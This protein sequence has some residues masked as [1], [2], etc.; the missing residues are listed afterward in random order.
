MLRTCLNA[1]LAA[2]VAFAAAPADAQAP[3]LTVKV[4][5]PGRADQYNFEIAF[6]RGYFAE[7]GLEV[8][9]VAANSAQEYVSAI[10]SNQIQVASG[11]PN[12]GLFN[13]LDR[14]IDI[15]MVADWAHLGD[16]QGKDSVAIVVRA[17]LFDSGA[18]KTIADLK[19]R[20]IA[21][22]P[23]K[24]MYPDVLDQ[25]MFELAK[26]A[27]ADVTVEYLA[28]ADALAAMSGKKIDAAFMVEPLITQAD[29][30]NIARVLVRAGA[31]DPGAELALLMYSAEF[32]KNKDAATKFMV[33][34]LKGARDYYDAFYMNKDRD[35]VIK[36]L[37]EYLPVKDPKLW[38]AATPGHTDLNGAIN[39]ADLKRQAAFFREQGTLS[40]AV[41]DLDKYVTAEFAD[42]AVKIIGRR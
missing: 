39:V 11:S 26:L 19:G 24:A 13:A 7:Q 36:L 20:T 29:S 15:R 9:T 2:F 32:A 31:V 34:Y 25:K 8:E 10:A 1:A 38:E 12:A 28:F 30:K 16:G 27:P 35:A 3:K 6:R 14:G 21:A 40:G 5:V 41:P 22:G 37:T 33:G 17:D 42:A 18:V 4:G 23:G